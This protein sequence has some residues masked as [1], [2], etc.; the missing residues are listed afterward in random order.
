MNARRKSL[1]SNKR[2]FAFVLMCV[3]ALEAFSAGYVFAKGKI[4]SLQA[5]VPSVEAFICRFS[6]QTLTYQQPF[7]SKKV[8]APTIGCKLSSASLCVSLQS[9]NDS[10]LPKKVGRSCLGPSTTRAYFIFSHCSEN[11]HFLKCI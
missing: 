2:F 11:N 3:Y 10:V 8:S 9:F 7:L 1:R 4:A 5:I 6:I